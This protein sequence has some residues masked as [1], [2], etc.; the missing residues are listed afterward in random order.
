MAFHLDSFVKEDP[1]FVRKMIDD[2]VTGEQTDDQALS[3][4]ENST[5]RL[6]NRSFKLRMWLSNTPKGPEGRRM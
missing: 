3:L 4:F 2:L 1:Q 5:K 6:G